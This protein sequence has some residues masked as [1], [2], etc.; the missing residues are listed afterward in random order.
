M[1]V[2]CMRFGRIFLITNFQYTSSRDQ[3]SRI[4]LNRNIFKKFLLMRETPNWCVIVL[5]LFPVATYPKE[6]P[7]SHPVRMKFQRCSAWTFHR[8]IPA[9][10]S[11]IS[12]S[13]S[14]L[15]KC[16]RSHPADWNFRRIPTLAHTMS[17]A[18]SISLILIKLNCL[19]SQRTATF[20]SAFNFRIVIS[21]AIY[22]VYH[23]FRMCREF[24]TCF[25]IQESSFKKITY[26]FSRE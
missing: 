17:R 7:R 18:L 5:L 26:W 9:P 23:I 11:N 16:W 22:R 10:W 4:L 3:E 14:R 15:E 12:R 21:F 25:L 6:M 20:Y 24:A 8:N 19:M 13:C 2:W 1:Y